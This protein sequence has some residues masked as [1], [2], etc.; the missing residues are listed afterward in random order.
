MPSNDTTTRFRA[1]VSQLKSAMQ[2]A[3]RSIRLANSEFKAATAGMTNWSNTADGLGAKIKQLNSVL[4]AQKQQLS[5]LEREYTRVAAAEGEDSRGAQ[6]LMIRMNNQRAA[7]A[8]TQASLDS[9]TDE[10]DDVERGNKKLSKSTAEAGKSA[11]KASEGFTVLKGALADLVASG[12][13]SAINGMM[14]LGAEAVKL[15]KNSINAYAQYEQLVGGV[16]TLFGAG[17][18]SLKEYAKSVG[19]TTDEAKAEFNKLIKAQNTVLKNSDE[20][21]KTSGMSANDYIETVTSFSASLM[22]GL[23]GDSTK[24]AELADKAVKDMSDNANKMGTSLDSIQSAY[25]GF[26]KQNFSMLDNLKIGYGGTQKEMFRLMQDAAKLDKTFAET[27]DF[28]IDSKGHL[29]A[30]FNDIIQAI[31]IVQ[32]DMGITGTTAKE[33]SQTIEG[34]VNSMKSAWDNLVRGLADDNADFDNLVKNFTNGAGTAFENLLPRIKTVISGIGSLAGSLIQNFAPEIV[35]ELPG[36][37]TDLSKSVLNV[38]PD[39]LNTLGKGMVST[40]QSMSPTIVGI[41]TQLAQMFVAGVP[42]FAQLGFD[43]L[44]TIVQGIVNNAPALLTQ[45]VE[46]FAQLIDVFNAN[47]P[48]MLDSLV[49][50]LNNFLSSNL[51]GIIGTLVNSAVTLL[52][53]GLPT[54]LSAAVSL[55]NGIVQAVPKIVQELKTQLPTIITSIVTTLTDSI[56]VIL[57]GAI[58]LFNGIIDALPVV[59]EALIEALPVII[60]GIVNFL[61]QNI[62]KIINTVIDLGMNVIDKLVNVLIPAFIKMAPK[63]VKAFITSLLKLKVAIF[64]AGFTLFLKLGE[65]I[66]KVWNKIKTAIGDLFG[67]IWEFLKTMPAKMADIGVNLIEGLWNGIK[68]MAGWIKDKITGFG[69]SVLTTLKDFF[70]IASPSKLMRDQVGRWIAKGLVAGIL[71]E[72]NNTIRAVKKNASKIANAYGTALISGMA[73]QSDNLIKTAKDS[74]KKVLSGMLDAARS[75]DFSGVATVA[76]ASFSEELTATNNYITRRLEAQREANLDDWTNR[77]EKQTKERDAR[78]KK[79]NDKA[80][81]EEKKTTKKYKKEISL[82]EQAGEAKK[83]ALQKKNE[84]QSEKSSEANEKKLEKLEKDYDKRIKKL[85]AKRKKIEDDPYYGNTREADTKKIDKKIESLKKEYKETV[86]AEQKAGKAE[87]KASKSRIAKQLKDIDKATAKKVKA[88]KKASKEEVK[89]IRA[90]AKKNQKKVSDSFDPGINQLSSNKSNY[91]QATKE[92]MEDYSNAMADYQKQ[93]EALINDTINGI[94]DTYTKRYDSL[95]NKQDELI[96]KLQSAGDLF[97]ISDNG[98][99]RV[100]DIKQQTENIK[101]YASK[102]QKIKAKVAPELFDEIAKMDMKEGTAYMDYLMKLSDTEL[103]TYSNAFVEKMETAKSVAEQMYKNDI[104]SIATD[105]ETELKKAF[106]GL[107]EEMEKLGEQVMAGFEAGLVGRTDW[108][109]DSVQKEIK[110]LIDMFKDSLGIASPSKVLMQIGEFA[111]EGFAKGLELTIKQV[112]SVASDIVGV[113]TDTLADVK[114]NIGAVKSGVMSGGTNSTNNTTNNYNF[115]QN[116]NSPKPLNRLEI[117]RQTKNQLNFAREVV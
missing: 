90:E 85:E 68:D 105:Y 101:E 6:E 25:Q 40:I 82:I 22:Q 104:D 57:D 100:N 30:S 7:I 117:Y 86:K 92:F 10:L 34:S 11:S 89:G 59:N 102:L 50:S 4:S 20:A 38:L 58:Q 67:N 43:I 12:M 23:G 31:H 63:L 78:L 109:K 19:K 94:A 91:E 47:F 52:Q 44:N 55:L 29:T 99:L 73:K 103:S 106:E 75:M 15:G 1:D 66:P 65:A 95:I 51:P 45:A 64:K 72:E 21:Y 79:I 14:K 71:A 54:I 8:R 77:I 13:K 112:K 41:L 88:H 60:D 24:A 98:I 83:K 81:K 114:G 76:G 116:N 27:A 107:P 46:S 115:V 80:Q 56:D 49:S 62:E 96:T 26:A 32:T 87:G 2:E 74:T 5:A 93:A 36:I 84:K 33:A 70:G 18:K 97:D 28:S 111:G 108:L 48:Q 53:N 69:E 3:S 17:G 35:A 110:T 42:Q 9:Y 37:M 39:A 113:T 16:E 61:D